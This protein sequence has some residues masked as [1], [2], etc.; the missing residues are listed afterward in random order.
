M[1]NDWNYYEKINDFEDLAITN[2]GLESFHQI[3]K[4]QLKRITPSFKGFVEV[5]AR[6]ETLK[7][8]DYDEDKV[9]GDPQYNR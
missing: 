8:S 3:I 4:S 2:N 7:K 6:A 1:I 5:L 9:N